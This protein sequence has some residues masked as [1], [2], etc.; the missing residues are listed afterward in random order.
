MNRITSPEINPH[1]Y[2]QVIF[3]KGVKNTQ[4]G[5][6]S[7]FDKWCREN[8]IIKCKRMKLDPSLIQLTKI[9]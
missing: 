5:K 9:N 2:S 6:D 1:I 4:W 7:L 3:D 8:K